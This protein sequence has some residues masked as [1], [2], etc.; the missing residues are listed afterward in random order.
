MY[1]KTLPEQNFFEDRN[2]KSNGKFQRANKQEGGSELGKNMASVV[3]VL[4]IEGDSV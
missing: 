2:V 4:V 3:V 1:L